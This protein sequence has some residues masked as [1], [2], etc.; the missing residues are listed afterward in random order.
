MKKI[1]VEFT[2]DTYIIEVPESVADH[3][4]KCQRAFDK[5]LYDKENDHGLWVIV[6]GKKMAVSFGCEDFVAFLNTTIT[7]ENPV[8]KI[9]GTTKKSHDDLP[10]IY[11]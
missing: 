3:I 2:Y 7:P 4:R 1:A 9:L 6:N 8:C 10:T 5:W 11:F